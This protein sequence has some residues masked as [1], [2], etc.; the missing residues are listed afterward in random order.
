MKSLLPV[1][2][3]TI[4]MLTCGLLSAQ[5]TIPPPLRI[6][7]GITANAY[8]GDLTQE[9]DNLWRAEPGANF[10]VDIDKQKPL[11]TQLNFGFGWFS[12]QA[13]SPLPPAPEGIV[14]N[15]FVRTSFFYTD[16]KLQYRF[17]RRL[18]FQ[19]YLATGLGL[20][21][22]QPRDEQGN[23]LGENIFS[24][25]PGEEY[26]TLLASIPLSAGVE[27]KISPHLALGCEYTLRL[28][29]SDYLDNI[30]LLG[31][32]DGNDHLHNL[33]L[34][35][36]FHIRPEAK[37]PLPM[38]LTEEPQPLPTPVLKPQVFRYKDGQLRIQ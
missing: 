21:S 10:S 35:L 28:T 2:S 17:L 19:P 6:G 13:D 12:E 31:E 33:Q 9:P 25:L 11:R 32:R 3:L 38:L 30:A 15:T 29:G 8:R 7:L 1:L 18:P 27:W 36:I 20:F 24:R 5:E 4:I 34:K 37:T 14:P 22:F 26:A 23:F 16:L